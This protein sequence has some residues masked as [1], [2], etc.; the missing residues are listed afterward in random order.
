M[1]LPA[2]FNLI[3]NNISPG[4]YTGLEMVIEP[5]QTL[6]HLVELSLKNQKLITR[7]TIVGINDWDNLLKELS[8]SHP[9]HLSINGKGILHKLLNTPHET[10]VVSQVLPNADPSD[11][12]W[13]KSPAVDG[14]IIS[15]I[16]KSQLGEILS[17]FAHQK[18]WVTRL[19][20]GPFGIQKMMPAI[21][22]QK[23]V[24]SFCHTLFFDHNK[25]LSNWEEND[26]AASHQIQLGDETLDSFLLPAYAAAFLGLTNGVASI[27]EP[28]Q[29]NHKEYQQY[30][31][32]NIAKRG[33]AIFFLGLLLA[34]TFAYF[35]FKNKDQAARS[36]LLS[37]DHQLTTI[38]TLKSQI[39]QQR[40]LLQSTS[41]QQ[42]T[43]TSYYADQI[44]AFLPSG[45]QLELL[46]IF[47]PKDK[48]VNRRK[49]QLVKYDK[50]SIS[51]KGTCENS[52]IY[53][54]WLKDLQEL[55]WVKH[56][57]HINYKDIDDELASFELKISL[58]PLK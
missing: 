47:P 44:A 13:Q 6:F 43:C 29:N 42:N 49:N 46:D 24:V 55:D 34:N 5:G 12:Y 18:L 40:D 9:I 36:A 56:T 31:I 19:S 1:K 54:K 4:T 3:Q 38:D 17:K 7:K 45:I 41:V 58:Q 28:V 11:F 8:K 10:Q 52:Q 35:Y 27:A 15:L 33:I 48:K 53:N 2:F 14:T 32:F 25:A 16:R 50:Q 23:K 22:E 37:V 39:A 20:L 57:K 51:I 26:M 21:P 30:R